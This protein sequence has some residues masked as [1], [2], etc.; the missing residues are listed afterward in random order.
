MNTYSADLIQG[1][2][3][4]IV[5]LIERLSAGESFDNPKLR[6]VADRHFNGSRAQGTYT[7][8]DAYDALETAVNRMLLEGK[9][10]ELMR[11]NPIDALTNYL[12]PLVKQLATQTDRTAEQNELQQ[13]S[14]PPT[15][16]YLAAR[17]LDP[18]AADIVLEPSAGTASLA[19]WPRSI[20]ARVLCNEINP[21]RRALLIEELGFETF[22]VDAE[23]I[24][25]LLPADIQPTAVLMNPP[26]SATG[27]RVV[28]HRSLY[29][30]K[31]IETALRRL[32]EG[33]RLVSIV[34]EGM[35]FHHSSF[36]QWWQRIARE[37][38]VRANFHLNGRE[39]GKYG[40]TFDVQILV[41][42]KT[43]ATPG[44]NWQ[45]QL[46]NICWGEAESLEEA[47]RELMQVAARLPLPVSEGE[48][49]EEGETIFVSYE[50]TKIKGGQPHPAQIVESTSMAAVLSPDITYRP[51]LT[52]QIISEGRLSAIQ[53][54]RVIY[55]GQRHEQRLPDGSR[56]GFYVGDGT[57]VGKGRILAGIIAD[58]WNQGRQRSLWLSVN[59]DLLEST[60]R[61][62]RDLGLRR[63][64]LARIND[65][66]AA[67]EISLPRGV[68]FSSYSSLIAAAKSGAK[69]LDQIQRWLGTDAV[70]ILDEAHKAK[71]ALAGGRGEPTQTGQAVIDLQDPA[72]NPDYRIVYSSAT[73]ATDV[74]NMAYMTRLGLWGKGTSF[75]TGFQEFMQ[76]IESGGVGAMEMV[77]RDLKALGMY[78]S[79]SIS[80][81]VCPN[82]GK[83][84]E[85]RERIHRLTPQQR[86]M[87]D[88]AARA[89]QVV[90]R[91]ID[92]AL[93]VTG[94]GTRARATALN[95]FW[96]DH[97]RFFRQ[98]ICA[99]KVPSVIA[100]TE[101]A[102]SEGKSA[103]ISLI[104][105]GEARTREQVAR[106]AAAGGQLEDLDFSPRE[107]IGA[108]IERGFP[109]TLYQDSTDPASGK[110]IQVP[111]TDEQG[112][113]VQSKAALAMRQRLIDGLSSLELPENPL[114]Q[115]VNHFG[116][117][118]VAELTGR[119]RRLIR[120]PQTGRVEY[121]KRAPEGV[122]MT[123]TN[124]YEME[125]FQQ[126]RKRIAIISDAA[127]TGISLHASNRAANKQRRV[128]ITLEL[129]WSADK[130]MQTFGRTH[131]SDQAV[132][133]EYVLLS[134]ELG[135]EKRFSSTIARRLGSL[136]ALTKG[137]RGAAD[138]SDLARYNF[139]TGEGC[140]ALSLTF[141]RIMA[142]ENVPGLENPR[143]TLRD[144]G[145]L[146]KNKDGGEEIRKEDEYNVPRFLNRVLALCVD[147]QNALF[148]Y[149]ADLF[150]QTVRYAKANGTF[151]EGVTDIKAL[152]IR[153]AKAPRIVY[154][155]QIT[156]AETT[157][158]TLEVDQPTEAV[159][160]EEADQKRQN[161]GGAFMQH[162][163]KGQF[164]LALPSRNHT[165]PNTGNSYR[166]F[167]VWKPEA[168]RAF[169]IY[170]AELNEKYQAVT[171][172]HARDWWMRKYAVIPPIQTLETH[173]IGGAIIPLWQSFKT[174]RETRLRV[175]RVSTDAG[176][177]I[178]GI[179]IPNDR[180]WAVLRS[181][182]IGRRLQEPAQIYNA[183][184][185]QGEELTLAGTLKLKQAN[186]HGEAIIE[187]HCTDPYKFGQLRELGL[188]NEQIK[189]KQR[190][191]IP[192]DED[193]GPEILAALLKVFPAS[194]TEE[195]TDEATEQEATAEIEAMPE[196]TANNV[197]DLEQWI[198]AAGE[199]EENKG[200]GNEEG[201]EVSPRASIQTTLLQEPD[202]SSQPDNRKPSGQRSLFG[203]PPT[204]SE[205]ESK[206]TKKK[207]TGYSYQAQLTFDFSA[208]E[209]PQKE[210]MSAASQAA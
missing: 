89:W 169:Y 174:D 80:F 67:G 40:T 30:A 5:E 117:R 196:S 16:A 171:P 184:L 152:A 181:L 175:V 166:S 23:I 164:I 155:D 191:F 94:G 90:L 177:R 186:L 55:A 123:R 72:T 74:R 194:A 189:W 68:I 162:R 136:G 154:K 207:A 120:D 3:S 44:D 170:E 27:G 95:K 84:V 130:Q 57:G 205:P 131:R 19:I 160:F 125:Q 201:R 42:D 81:G 193:K 140:A 109:T 134:T 180:V 87:Y 4:L 77:S 119:T 179:H 105:T 29:G 64:P 99:F 83:A 176:Q 121:K 138:N 92:A 114:D 108:M 118:K 107:V 96:G 54:E 65:F 46:K 36:S 110:T 85:Y 208:L 163:K 38:N 124:V 197:I 144:I 159:T 78:L 173:I 128:H 53:V 190:F 129:G 34:G 210:S 70:I 127:S 199:I 172:E 76:E 49:G 133:P 167:S 200:Q 202:E 51:H 12:R 116:E 43:G 203:E 143:Q 69:R 35:S 60:R 145:L 150:D 206:R 47:E 126:G 31:H 75:P 52:P 198:I 148:N 158:Y 122:A 135:G 15:L 178:V 25:D 50:P 8:R 39:Y 21:R 106:A 58:N 182:G 26:F 82:S 185:N 141:R 28:H 91:N 132:P 192:A 142:G 22:A 101:E 32:Q 98:V 71:N 56:A 104:G 93:E 157:H 48:E 115:L 62:L 14:T 156:G 103:V 149:F 147:E 195:A 63:I 161:W 88:N 86:E 151:D 73:G 11:M 102:L 209:P 113:I 1:T 33:G 153:L 146:V 97:Q 100:E 139:E 111:V 112:N 20:G 187:L 168:P 66:A 7:P 10:G 137:D 61:D 6:E 204:A 41:I 183:V 17:V 45:E 13:F 37:Y 188:I 18:Q 59:N 165:D 79:G 9:A 24:D 2:G